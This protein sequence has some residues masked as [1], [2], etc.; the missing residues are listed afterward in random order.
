MKALWMILSLSLAAL[1]Q[2]QDIPP[3]A[4]LRGDAATLKDTMKFLQDK[5]P[6]KVNYIVYEHNNVTGTDSPPSKRS[7]EM[8]SVKADPDHCYIGYHFRLD[9]GTTVFDQDSGLALKQVRE[10]T[11]MSLE[12]ST[13][14]GNAKA[15]HPERSVR[16]DPPVFQVLV[17]SESGRPSVI[18]LFYDDSMSDRVSK[19][20]MHAVD[21]CG[22][23][24]QEPF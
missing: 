7:L 3:L 5:L 14:Q 1:V 19:A 8:S 15:G 2:A 17:Q 22:G 24:R 12:Q 18:G 6:G 21:L 9:N 16:V 23:G 11:S 4:P 13:Q 20:L 10:I